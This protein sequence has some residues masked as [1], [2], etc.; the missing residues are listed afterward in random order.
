ML[1]PIQTTLLTR[2]F[3]AIAPQADAFAADFYDTL[4]VLALA[5]GAS[6]QPI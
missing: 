5:S 3:A 1:T 4:F 2:Q 6:F